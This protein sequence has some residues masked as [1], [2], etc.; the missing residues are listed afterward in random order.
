MVVTLFFFLGLSSMETGLGIKTGKVNT[1]CTA[2]L[3]SN[4]A[5]FY[6]IAYS[7]Q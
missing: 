1:V 5:A 3:L 2:L 6:S 7:P 4:K